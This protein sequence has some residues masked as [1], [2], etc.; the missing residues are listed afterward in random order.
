MSRKSAIKDKCK[1]CGDGGYKDRQ[2]CDIA[3]CPLHPYRLGECKKGESIERNMSIKRFCTQCCN[4]ERQEVVN[5]PCED[6]AL[7]PYRGFCRDHTE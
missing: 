2:N 6:C 7:Y 4:G 5:C 1:D 3:N